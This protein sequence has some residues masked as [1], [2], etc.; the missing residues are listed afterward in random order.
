MM[1]LAGVLAC[2]VCTCA[3][4]APAQAAGRQQT[5]PSVTATAT[6][7]RAALADLTRADRELRPADAESTLRPADDD[8]LERR[9]IARVRIV[10]GLDTLL[11][12]GVAGRAAIRQL[13]TEWPGVDLVRRAE[14]RAAFR[15]S[16]ATDALAVTSKFALT[17]P[18]D[19]QL[20]RWR[21]EALESLGRTTEALR[22]R[23]ARFELAPEE[24]AGWRALLAAHEAAGS[25][26]RLRESLG[27]LRLLYPDSRIVREQ[28]IEV[29]HRLGRR[30]EAARLA[31]DTTGMNP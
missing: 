13:A 20:L 5:D 28:E 21:A 4:P 6:G 19:T 11:D 10:A 24:A 3:L 25:L 29:L 15:A 14:I 22:A 27:R 1:R 18:R 7:L 23:Q 31:A 12:A 26:P 9:A 30:D 16:D 8:A 17:A 2:F